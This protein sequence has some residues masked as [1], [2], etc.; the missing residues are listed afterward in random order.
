MECSQEASGTRLPILRDASQT[1]QDPQFGVSAVDSQ[2]LDTQT[3]DV[4]FI[5]TQPIDITQDFDSQ[6][7]EVVELPLRLS[8]RRSRGRVLSISDALNADTPPAKK[9][10]NGRS[11]AS[12]SPAPGAQRKQ[13][14]APF[15]WTVEWRFR[16]MNEALESFRGGFLAVD[17]PGAKGSGFIRDEMDKWATALSA[18]PGGENITL[19]KVR[20]RW[21]KEKKIYRAIRWLIDKSGT[22][23]DNETGMI[24]ASDA[25]WETFDVNFGGKYNI[26]RTK[27]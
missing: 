27:L 26:F 3:V 14:A 24:E 6:V 4:S 11:P 21:L 7:D 10:R 13:R 19:E 5:G 2:V 1:S 20:E 8:P 23:F 25:N 15:R 17:K 12:Q 18:S 22:D 16:L 9:Q